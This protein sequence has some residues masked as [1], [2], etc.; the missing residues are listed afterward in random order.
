M[1]STE[2]DI[3]R[4]LAGLGLWSS[5]ALRF[6][7]RHRRRSLAAGLFILIGC[8]L[9]VLIH[10]IAVGVDDAMVINTTALH[11][12]DA[13]IETSADPQA[14][15]TRMESD[16]A[17]AAAL[18]RR[19]LTALAV[20]NEGS[21]SLALYRVDPAREQAHAAVPRRL[22]A[23]KYPQEGDELLLG[24]G[25]AEALGIEIGDTLELLLADGARLSEL[26]LVG[27]FHTHIEQFDAHTAYMPLSDTSRGEGEIA[28][29]FRQRDHANELARLQLEHGAQLRP[30]HEL[31]PDLLQLIEMNDISVALVMLF[32]FILVGFGIGNL[33]VL[34]TLERFREFGILKAMGVTPGELQLMV[35]L[36]SLL[37]GL[38]ATTAGLLL[39]WALS[40]LLALRGIDFSTMTSSNRYFVMS[41]MVHPRTTTEGLWQ[42]GALALT[43]SLVAAYIPARIAAR[44]AAAQVLNAV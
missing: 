1:S 11:H 25:A 33:F 36:E 15:A 14:L 29:F 22:V 26:T 44:R 16:P 34:T 10:A 24:Q 21:T 28:L 41:G 6:V 40:E 8:S 32:V 20:G 3:P 37:I 18:P 35:F 23:G 7:G 12:G 39:G 30:W 19:R 9:L 17:V 2:G 4:G 5:L 27:L 38:L 42:P 13:F 43:V 31:R